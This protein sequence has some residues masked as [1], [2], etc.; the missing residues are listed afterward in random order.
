MIT[1]LIQLTKDIDATFGEVSYDTRYDEYVLRFLIT[2]MID[3]EQKFVRIAIS[4]DFIKDDK[5]DLV[6]FLKLKMK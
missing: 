5:I 6:E 2:Y 1:D 3:G 4:P